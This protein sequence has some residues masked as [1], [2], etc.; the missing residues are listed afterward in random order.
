MAGKN[1][2]NLYIKLDDNLNN[3]D[4][5]LKKDT[6]LINNLLSKKNIKINNNTI[7]IAEYILEQCFI[8]GLPNNFYFSNS[9]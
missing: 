9:S 3:T 5:D 2:K 8:D 6:D 7:E 4:N 1:M